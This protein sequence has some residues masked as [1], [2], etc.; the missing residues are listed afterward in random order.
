MTRLQ[1][2]AAIAGIAALV[3][4]ATHARF[5]ANAGPNCQQYHEKAVRA[6][7][8]ASSFPK[9]DHPWKVAYARESLAWSA[10]AAN[11]RQQ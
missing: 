11:C 10:I 4:F 6:A 9:S 1:T 8:T 7:E 2:V 5:P 3:L